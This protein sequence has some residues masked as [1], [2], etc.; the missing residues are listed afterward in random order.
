MINEYYGATE[1]GGAVF[2]TAREAL[3]RPGTV[4]R[5][6]AGATVRIYD[7]AGK[8]LGPGEVGEVY[9]RIE[10][11]PDFTYH[12][13]DAKRES[14][15]REGLVTAGDVGYL[16]S[17]GYLFLCDRK[18]DMVISGG[19]NI[20]PAEI[21]AALI[22]MPGVRDCAVFGIPD[23]EFGETLCAYVEAQEARSLTAAEVRSYLHGKLAKYKV[24]KVVEFSTALPREDSGKIFKRKLRAPYWEQAGRQ[25]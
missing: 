8:V 3:E 22:D 23:E 1:T 17:D 19:V 7:P 11:F 13:D 18:N 10:G 14:I 6:I 9:L 15:E 25:I 21:E 16:D 2:H 20:Y 12:G 24:P 4:G 5:P